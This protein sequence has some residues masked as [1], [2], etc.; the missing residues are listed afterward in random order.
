MKKHSLTYAVLTATLIALAPNAF[1]QD[2]PAAKADEKKPAAAPGEDEGM[3][4]WMEAATPGAPHKVLDPTVG[5]W[6]V[7]SKWWMDPS[8]PPQES[9][10]TTSKKWVM[11]GRFVQEDFKGDMMGM[12]MTGHGFTGYDNVKKKYNSFW[13]DTGGTAMYTS[14]GK[15]SGDGKTLT[16]TSLM[17]DPMTGEKDKPVRFIL[18]VESKDKHVFEMFETAGGKEKKVAEMTY[19]RK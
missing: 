4:K 9:K 5:E 3:K 10:G 15:A 17:D 6:E 19:T 18:K 7:A 16:F 11:D 8:A 2:K 14:L 1:A 13:I 12:P